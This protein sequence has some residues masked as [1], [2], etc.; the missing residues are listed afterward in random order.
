MSAVLSGLGDF[1][2]GLGNHIISGLG[3]ILSAILQL[4]PDSPFVFVMESPIG[5]YAATLSWI[6]PIKECIATLELWLAAIVIY[7]CVQAV[8]RWIKAIE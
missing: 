3:L 5:D 6:L 4:L 7:Y 8:L 2:I 1:L